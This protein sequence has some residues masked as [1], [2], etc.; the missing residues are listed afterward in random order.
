[1]SYGHLI[2][3]G[4]PGA[5]RVSSFQ[6]GHSME[7]VLFGELDLSNAPALE[8]V[9]ELA[10]EHRERARA[11]LS[12]LIVDLRHLDFI[13][14]TGVRALIRAQRECRRRSTNLTLLLDDDSP[15]QRILDLADVSGYLGCR[16]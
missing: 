3:T 12:E 10:L 5:L 7:F 11:P 2:D 15:A 9:L 4:S 14:A 16:G 1:M 13:D 6:S 8:D